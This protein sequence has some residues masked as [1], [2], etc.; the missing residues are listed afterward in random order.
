MFS[1]HTQEF[2]EEIFVKAYKGQ[3]VKQIKKPYHG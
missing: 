1:G 2:V 3:S